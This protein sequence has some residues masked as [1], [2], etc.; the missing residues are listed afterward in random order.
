MKTDVV[1]RILDAMRQAADPSAVTRSFCERIFLLHDHVRVLSVGKAGVTMMQAGLDVFDDRVSA[2]LA[3]APEEQC[4]IHS[5]DARVRY[6]PSDHPLPTERSVAAAEAMLSFVGD[7]D[8]PLVVLLSGGGSAM[9]TNPADGVSIDDLRSVADGL[10]RA[11]ATIDELNCVRKHLDLAKG[12]HVG[13]ATNGR[14][15]MVGVISDVLGD[16]LDVI[17]S[18]PFVGDA[19]VFADARRVLDRWGVRVAAVDGVIGRGREGAVEETPK[20]G[21]LRLSGI[22]HEVLA[23]NTIVAKAAALEIERGITPVE[24]HAAQAGQAAEWGGM[25]AERLKT[26]VGAIVLGGEPVVSG[27]PRGSGGGPM[28]EAVLAAGH[29]LHDT[30]GWLVI[31]YATDG[32]DGPTGAAGAVLTPESVP[33]AQRCEAALRSHNSF[34]VLA[35]A[36]A[37]LKGGPTGTNLNDVLIGIRWRA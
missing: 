14:P 1:P 3:I 37:I 9:V 8:E 29:A 24:V 2:G 22:R 31:G 23:S 28:Q 34:P 10:M 17:S 36:G 26:G 27:V 30:P 6:A 20:P 32:V 13:V 19:S 18:G 12:G 4:V 35:D 16:R 25:V 33:D 15:V 21:D 11:G 7:G 5:P